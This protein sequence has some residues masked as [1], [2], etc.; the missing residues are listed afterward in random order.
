MHS[1]LRFFVSEPTGDPT[2]DLED[3]D[4]EL[5]VIVRVAVDAGL[6]FVFV[7]LGFFFSIPKPSVRLPGTIFRK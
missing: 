3:A 6:E 1:S 5:E 4:E 7:E 2:A